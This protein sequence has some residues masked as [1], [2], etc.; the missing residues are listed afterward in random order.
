MPQL[1]RDEIDILYAV[2]NRLTQASTPVEWLEAISSYARD[3]GASSGAF[4]WITY[5]DDG[6]PE[7]AHIAAEWTTGRGMSASVG[8]RFYLPD[9]AGLID[10]LQSTP[11]RARLI[12]NTQD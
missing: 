9:F 10:L 2:S 3:H 4:F 6:Q 11:D 12:S 7:W 8:T 5:D 1:I